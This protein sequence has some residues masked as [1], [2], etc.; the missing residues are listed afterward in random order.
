MEREQ[1]QKSSSS[2]FQFPPGFRFHP[3]DEELIV[4]Y[5]QNKVTSKP[6]PA[7]I[8]AEIDLYKYNPWELPSKALFGESEWYFFSP[9]ERKYPKGKRPNRSAGLGYWKATGI[10]KP[11][12]GSSGSKQVGVKKG[13]VFYTGK[14]LKGEKTDWMMDEYRLLDN[15]NES[16]KLKGSMRVSVFKFCTRHKNV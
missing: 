3:S 11:I 13:L 15:S 12:F 14:P 16:S 8:I 4:Y 2:V 5:L 9:R 1:Q 10:D 7:S 6:L